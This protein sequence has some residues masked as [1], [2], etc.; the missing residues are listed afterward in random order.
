MADFNSSLPV[1]TENNGDVVSRI[2]DGTVTSQLLAVNADGSINITDNGGSITVDGTVTVTATNL[3]IRD[4]SH[5][6]DSVKLG[7]GTDFVAVNADGSLNIT[8]NGGSLTVDATN[9]DIRDLVFATDKVDVSGSSVTVT[10]TDLDIRDLSHTQ[11]S[12]K[13]GDGTDFL[14]IN[15]DGSINVSLASTPA[16]DEINDYNTASGIAA[17]ASSNH[18]YTV[19]AGKTFYLKQ[20][21]A[22]GSGKMKIE[23]RIETSA[24]SGTFNTRF[25]QFNSTATPNMGIH[26]D[27]PIT[28]AAGVKVRV[29]RTN[30]DGAGQD[31][32]STISGQEV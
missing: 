4:L 28:V 25:V 20:I 7:D 19:S 21:E 5:T 31:V 26:L 17:N 1:R 11:D 24:G 12:V 30:R 15:A 27:A 14:A 13:I 9:L 22:S 2:S 23:V 18:D 29:V 6:Q 3:D 16:G 8:D 32:Y 10:A